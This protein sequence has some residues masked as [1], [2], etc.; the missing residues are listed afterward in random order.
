MT[1]KSYAK[2]FRIQ[3][4]GRFRGVIDSFHKEL[5][6]N[7]ISDTDLS[8]LCNFAVCGQASA[9][10]RLYRADVIS[11]LRKS[12]IC[13]IAVERLSG[14][15]EKMTTGLRIQSLTAEKVESSA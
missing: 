5:H 9:C 4:L 14:H 12:R 15:K 1:G 3:V 2:T 8:T 11:I 10:R 13:D 6:L 7:N